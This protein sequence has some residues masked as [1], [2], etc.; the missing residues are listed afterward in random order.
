MSPCELV[1]GAVVIAVVGEVAV[2]VETSFEV[3]EVVEVDNVVWVS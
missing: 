2:V 1:D 3:A